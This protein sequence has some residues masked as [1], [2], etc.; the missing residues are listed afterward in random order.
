MAH[1]ERKHKKENLFRKEN[2]TTTQT[3]NYLRRSTHHRYIRHTKEFLNFEGTRMPMK[4]ASD[5]GLDYTPLYNF[6][7]KSVGKPFNDVYSEAIERMKESGFGWR[8]YKEPIFYIIE[9]NTYIKDGV[10]Y[11]SLGK[12]VSAISRCG[13]SAYYDSMFIDDEGIL[14]FVK[15]FNKNER[16]SSSGWQFGC[17]CHTHSV[18]GNPQ[19]HASYIEDGEYKT[20]VRF[21]QLGKK[22]GKKKRLGK[23]A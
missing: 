1:G 11:D 3:K 19:Y 7:Q 21:M 2:K 15:D 17:Y 5:L 18:N 4:P 9:K 20:R 12:E 8:D 13:E 16:V 14:R 23:Q 10:V 6:L 22:F